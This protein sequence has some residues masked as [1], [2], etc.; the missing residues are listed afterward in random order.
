MPFGQHQDSEPIYYIFFQVI[1][2]V[3]EL[4]IMVS[5]KMVVMDFESALWAAVKT[6]L[7]HVEVMGCAF[8]WTQAVWRKVSNEDP[9]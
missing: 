6:R 5:V 1:R 3:L 7:P 4:L 9:C 8:H 2:K